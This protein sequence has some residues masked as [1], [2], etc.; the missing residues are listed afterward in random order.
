MPGQHT[1][2]AFETAIEDFLL[3]QG[4]YAK[5][6]PEGYDPARGLFPRVFLDFVRETQPKEWE[7]L[8]GL[9]KD[10]AEE[11]LLDDLCPGSRLRARGLPKGPAPR[12]QVLWE[13]FSC[14]LLR[15]GER[16]KPRDATALRGQPAC[17]H[18]AA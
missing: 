9:Q 18:A 6:E 2:A 17:R 11:T 12:L 10:K 1:E 5:I 7:Y 13:I 15:A 3:S 4:G 14:G 16:L 8:K